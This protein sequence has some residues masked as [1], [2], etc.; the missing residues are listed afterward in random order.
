MERSTARKVFAVA[1]F[2]A[3]GIAAYLMYR[4]GES[5]FAIAKKAILN[6]IG[7]F[8]S[9]VHTVAVGKADA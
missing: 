7:S 1:T 6:P 3:G 9:E 8:A 4:R 5:P 2:V